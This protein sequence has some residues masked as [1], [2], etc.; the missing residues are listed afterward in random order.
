M[1]QALAASAEYE[2]SPMWY[3]LSVPQEL[4][5]PQK[6]TRRMENV[7]VETVVESDNFCLNRL[8][9]AGPF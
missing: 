4:L 6:D 1:E 8:I 2:Q 3:G 5:E 9:A 7:D